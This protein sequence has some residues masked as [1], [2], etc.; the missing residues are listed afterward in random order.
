MS[1]T[2]DNAN[3]RLNYKK[4]LKNMSLLEIVQKVICKP[5]FKNNGQDKG[6]IGM[7]KK[8]SSILICRNK[9]MKRL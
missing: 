9:I 4:C 2:A 6:L 3:S 5:C 8:V 1:T 7:R